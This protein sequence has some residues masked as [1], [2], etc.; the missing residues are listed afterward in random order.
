[1]NADQTVENGDNLFQIFINLHEKA[2]ENLF[3][4][5]INPIFSLEY[6]GSDMIR[7]IK[8]QELILD[9]KQNIPNQIQNMRLNGK[10]VFEE[11]NIFAQQTGIVGH[12]IEIGFS[13]ENQAKIVQAL[14]LVEA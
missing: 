9:I 1:M 5:Y 7:K 6:D 11:F 2:P 13:S 10:K 8:A 14:S 3:D 4:R 12:D